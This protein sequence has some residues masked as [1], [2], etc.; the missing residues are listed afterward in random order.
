MNNL[1]LIPFLFNITKIYLN[2]TFESMIVTFLKGLDLN[3]NVILFSLP[4]D[5]RKYLR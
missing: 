4:H 2:V 5:I 1:L 3:S